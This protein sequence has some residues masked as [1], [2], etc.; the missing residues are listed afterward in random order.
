[1]N[2]SMLGA[3]AMAPVAAAALIAA[4]SMPASASPARSAAPQT[5]SLSCSAS[6][7]NGHP[8]DYT[9]TGVQV[10]TGAEAGIETVAHYKTTTHPKYGTASSSGR[11]TIWYYISG[12]TPGYR[13]VVD[14]YVSRDGRKASCSTSFTPHR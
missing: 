6:M 14:V 12:A 10:R 2:K 4:L 8:A 7:T 3:T 5:A 1:M 13:V 9:S 11:K